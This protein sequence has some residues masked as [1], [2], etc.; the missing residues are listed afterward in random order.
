M[1]K[2]VPVQINA[3]KGKSKEQVEKETL[4]TFGA[5][6]DAIALQLPWTLEIKGEKFK[7]NRKSVRQSFPIQS[8]LIK[9]LQKAYK[10]IDTEK[11]K[12]KVSE[13]LSINN[14]V[15]EIIDNYGNVCEAIE[16]VF[17][18]FIDHYLEEE[19]KERFEETMDMDDLNKTFPDIV[20]IMIP[21][22]K[23]PIEIMLQIGQ[24]MA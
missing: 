10:Q 3:K 17:S 13:E 22:L 12:E 4:D 23:G 16:E 7:I 20:R 2:K 15:D 6:M 9:L 11:I 18:I 24:K 8:K 5:S 14:F 1:A 19:D 21:L